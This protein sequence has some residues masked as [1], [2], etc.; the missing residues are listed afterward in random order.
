[1]LSKFHVCCVHSA[2]LGMNKLTVGKIYAGMLI[3]ENWRAYKASSSQP[4]GL[5]AQVTRLFNQ[6]INPSRLFQATRPI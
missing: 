5:N 3:V 1:V 2:D 6:S 4:G